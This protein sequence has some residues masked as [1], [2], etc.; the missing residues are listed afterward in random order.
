MTVR[1]Y[2]KGGSVVRTLE[3]GSLEAGSYVEPL[4][5]AHWDGRNDKGELVSS[6]AY[7]AEMVAGDYRKIRRIVLVK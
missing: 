7:F 6:G 2:D 5:A 4:S 3:L 1:I